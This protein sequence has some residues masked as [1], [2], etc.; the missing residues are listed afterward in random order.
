MADGSILIEA[1]ES[2]AL[3]PAPI[4]PDWILAGAPEARSRILARTHDRTA[5]IAVWECTAGRF[6]W[7]Y[8]E[9]ETVVI[10]SGEVFITTE[11]GKERRLGQGDVGFFPA[12]SSCTW[13]ISDRVRKVAT[14]RKDLP[15]VLGIGVRVWH[16]LLRAVKL[17]GSSP[18][19]SAVRA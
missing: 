2:A 3:D 4:S 18:L 14:L 17:R 10:I 16:R 13:H 8:S 6:N 12:G 15:P 19:V 5:S 11:D 1:A 7:Y 9:D